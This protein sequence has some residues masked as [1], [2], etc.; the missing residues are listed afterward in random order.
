V[1]SQPA[2]SDDDVRR[3]GICESTC[4]SLCPLITG[5]QWCC[6]YCYLLLVVGVLLARASSAAVLGVAMQF[7][8]VRHTKPLLKQHSKH[9]AGELH[10][11][12][13][14]DSRR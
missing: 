7:I 2:A 5:L 12:R 3:G 1:A 6:D 8:S 10:G 11:R 9:G 13:C 14:G 4:E